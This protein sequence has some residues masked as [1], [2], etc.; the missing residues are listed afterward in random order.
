MAALTI[1]KGVRFNFFWSTSTKPPGGYAVIAPKLP[2]VNL[3]KQDHLSL[4]A[5]LSLGTESDV[6]QH[7]DIFGNK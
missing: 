1:I 2:D 4:K 5:S 7:G 6:A 3:L